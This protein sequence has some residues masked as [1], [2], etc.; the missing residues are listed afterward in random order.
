[1]DATLKKELPQEGTSCA[2]ESLPEL[3]S[4][5]PSYSGGGTN[6]R[7]NVECSVES[8][9]EDPTGPNN[10]VLE[11]NNTTGKKKLTQQVFHPS[12]FVNRQKSNTGTAPYHGTMTNKD[13]DPTPPDWQRQ[14]TMRNHKRKKISESPS[15]EKLKTSNRFSGLPIDLTEDEPIKKKPNKPPPIILYGI[16]DVNKLTQLLNTVTEQDRFS[17]KIVNR[18]QLRVSCENTETYK[19]VITVV[20]E[21]GLIGH[22]FNKKEDRCFRIVIRNLH[23]T[24][25]HEAI[26]EEIE[27]TGNKVSGE[28]I[29]VKYG[30]DKKPTSTFFVNLFPSPENRAVKELKYIY[31]QSIV[32]EDPKRRKSIVQ[33]QRCQQYGHSKNYCM[34]PYR[35]V[36]CKEP[37]KTSE[38]NKRDRNTPAQCVLCDG[39]HPANYKGCQ[40]YKEIAARKS[41]YKNAPRTQ[42]RSELTSKPTK[43]PDTKHPVNSPQKDKTH[44]KTYYEAL[45]SPKAEKKEAEEHTTTF[46]SS[47][48]H[49]LLKQSEQV[50]LLLQQMSTLVNLI[51][52]LVS[53]L[54][55]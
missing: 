29:N 22:T 42:Y 12:L 39:P 51:T 53:K 37:H 18:N 35:C 28:I 23:H 21:K 25:P 19:K 10:P 43:E 9:T 15:P 33:C 4:G 8:A 32:I 31:H 41:T 45:N 11:A 47:I 1:M 26:I 36:K 2:G 3:N 55:K 24:T 13:K 7:H 38:C 20:R 5:S 46:N 50:N 40:V 17:F 48:E 30:P 14:P 6:L 49:I 54:S 34:R 52:T 44:H 16:E 27:K